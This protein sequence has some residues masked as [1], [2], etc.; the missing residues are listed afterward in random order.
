[1]SEYNR[2]ATND[3]FE[4]PISMDGVEYSQVKLRPPFMAVAPIGDDWRLYI[5]RGQGVIMYAPD[6]ASGQMPLENGTVIGMT[7][8]T[9]HSF[10]SGSDDDFSHHES[11]WEECALGG[12]VLDDDIQ[13]LIGRI[14]QSSM[15]FL[16][17]MGGLILI[18][19][20]HHLGA[21]NRIGLLIDL[22][23][24]ETNRNDSVTGQ[25]VLRLA[26][27]I[28]MEIGRI[29]RVDSIV[30]S[31]RAH[32]AEYDERIW[33]AITAMCSAPQLPWTLDSMA[34]VAGMSRSAFAARYHETV[35]QTPVRSLRRLRMHGAAMALSTAGPHSIAPLADKMGYGSDAAFNRAFAKEFGY[36]PKRYGLRQRKE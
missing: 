21:T 18:E 9:P 31:N 15:P 24:D 34:K 10:S 36:P 20:K 5:V 11:G 29:G 19:P 14:P 28:T 27:I 23:A 4:P 1:M 26:D 13:I 8:N 3:H 7:G 25:I 16:S 17:L 6:L 35:G 32:N 30:F 33:R 22:I 2:P 12:D